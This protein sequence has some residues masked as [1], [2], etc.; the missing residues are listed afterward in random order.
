MKRKEKRINEILKGVLKEI[1]PTEKEKTEIR[2]FIDKIINEIR[3]ICEEENIKAK[4]MVVGSLARNTWLKGD[5]DIDI[6]LLLPV[7]IGKKQLEQN[8]KRIGKKLS[9]KEK[10][11]MVIKYAEHPYVRLIFNDY[12]LDLVPCYSVKGVH[13][14]KSSVDRTPFHVKYLAA[15]MDSKRADEVRLLKQFMKGISVYGSDMKISGFSGYL[16]ELLILKYGGFIELLNNVSSWGKKVF[17]DIEGFYQGKETPEKFKEPLVVVDPVDVNRNAA[18]AVSKKKLSRF[19]LAAVNFLEN[20]SRKFFFKEEK[21]ITLSKLKTLMKERD[22]Y[23]LLIRFN[24]LVKEPPEIIW[25]QLSKLAKKIRNLAEKKDVK[26]LDIRWWTDEEHEGVIFI[27]T[28]RRKLSNIKKHY[29]PSVLQRDKGHVEKFIKKHI[30][31]KLVIRGPY[32]E[33]DR[34]VVDLKRTE[35]DVKKII[36]DEVINRNLKTS[37][38]LEE[39]LKKTF[40]VFDSEDLERILKSSFYPYFSKILTENIWI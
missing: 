26:V 33:E 8:V 18:A 20:P 12:E 24:L 36:A 19:I 38:S 40:M 3:I 10:A 35:T 17:I 1:K 16:C 4:P 15:R 28:E 22:T 31:N 25:S 30:Q 21:K 27:E 11:R 5:K 34:L 6:F 29:G 7:E 9:R 32:L 37:S 14:M 23:W 2:E 39:S 13:E